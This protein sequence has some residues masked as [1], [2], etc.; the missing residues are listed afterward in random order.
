MACTDLQS[1]DC[2]YDQRAAGG[3]EAR[4]TPAARPAPPRLAL[5]GPVGYRVSQA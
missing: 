5:A 2:I 1:A 4:E 3:R